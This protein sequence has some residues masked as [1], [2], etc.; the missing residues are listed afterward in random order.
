MILSDGS[1]LQ[2][3]LSSAPKT[4]ASDVY[5]MDFGLKRGVVKAI[6]YPDQKENVTKQFVEYDVIVIEERADGAAAT[7]IYSR[8]QTMDKFCT[9]ND[10]ETFVLQSNS[11]KDKGRYKQGAQVLLLAINGNAAAAKGIIVGGVSYPFA[12]KPQ[13]SDGKYYESQ[14]N[15]LNVKIDKDGQYSLTFNSPI[16]VNRKKTNAKAAGTKMEIFKDGRMKMS[17]NEGQYWEIDRANQKSIWA[18]GAESIIIDKKNK[19]IDLVTSGTMSETIK[20]SKTTM[21]TNK[22]HSIETA[23]GSIIEKSGKDINREAKAN[24]IEKAGANWMFEAGA[25]V[26]IKS[27]GNVQIQASGNAQLKGVLNLIG[28]GSVLAAG[29][30][31][32][33]CFGIG[34]LGGPVMSNIITGSSTVLI[35]A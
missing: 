23:S 15:G 35:G 27:G 7:V 9:P 33:Q 34:N 1:I 21:V 5:R 32:S 3:A 14:F 2:S 20:D 26:I 24:I 12:T 22:D 28:D 10:F 16:D 17:D 31:I 11:E 8:C 29:V 6:Y 30:G 19:K 13:Q 18:N 4:K 25:N